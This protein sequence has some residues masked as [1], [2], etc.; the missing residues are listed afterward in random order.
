[1]HILNINA[2]I[3]MYVYVYIDIYMYIYMYLYTGRDIGIDMYACVYIYIY[4]TH[5]EST[6]KISSFLFYYRVTCIELFRVRG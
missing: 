5:L 3:Y 4:I 6:F 1:M 2:I